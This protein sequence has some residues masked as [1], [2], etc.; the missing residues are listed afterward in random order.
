MN[1]EQRDECLTDIW[2]IVAEWRQ[3]CSNVVQHYPGLSDP[4]RDGEP[5]TS[6]NPGDC[7]ECTK[8]AMEAIAK[9]IEGGAQSNATQIA[10]VPKVGVDQTSEMPTDP[11]RR[12]PPPEVWS[13]DKA[14]KLA[15]LIEEL[16]RRAARIGTMSCLWDI[17]GDA[18]AALKG[19][20]AV[21]Q[22]SLDEA[23]AECE[24]ALRN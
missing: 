14:Q 16:R 9:A 19:G 8:A 1:S 5:P 22:W 2:E 11:V 20:K 24:M 7:P 17:I 21:F 10:I 23:I 18:E 3:G 6:P 13:V 4:E 15:Y 12:I